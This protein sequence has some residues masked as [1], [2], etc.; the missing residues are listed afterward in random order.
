M[1]NM[2]TV[3]K[4]KKMNTKEVQKAIPVLRKEKYREQNK[5]F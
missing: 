5:L 1:E 3:L 4:K 2:E